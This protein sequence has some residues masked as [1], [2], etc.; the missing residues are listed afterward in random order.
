MGGSVERHNNFD[1]LRLVAAISVIFSHAFLL[2]E[3]TQDP[4]PLYWLTGGQTVLGVVGVF[5]FFTISGYL[6]TQSFEATGSPVRFLAKRGLRIYPGLIAC[7]LVSAF[8]MGPLVSGLDPAAYLLSPGVYHYVASNFAMVMPANTL[9]GVAFS[10]YGAGSVVDG[11]LWT[12]PSEVMM[13]L[14]VCALG[15]L[16]FLSLPA[17]LPLLLLGLGGLWFDTASSEYFIGSALWL[18][19]FFAAGMALYRLR[20]KKILRHG[21]ALM[22]LAGL[23]LSVPFHAFI[24]LFPIF[25]SYLV[26]YLAFAP[27]FPVV[28]A[29]RFG[30]L[31]YGLYSNGS[32]VS[33]AARSPGRRSSRSPCR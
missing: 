27:W 24:L 1:A 19:P 16:R 3:G 14:M 31:S 30:D 6:V 12:L 20:N 22:A 25:G 17:M 5:V 11:P 23:V 4:E 2:G 21:L 32:S 15:I 28:R 8:V 29:A 7:L 26:I 10:G 33:T 18:L 9:P 13:Y